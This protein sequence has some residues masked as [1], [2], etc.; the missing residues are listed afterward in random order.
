MHYRAGCEGADKFG[1][2]TRWVLEVLGFL[3]RGCGID[4]AM[5]PF[6]AIELRRRQLIVRTGAGCATLVMF[7]IAAV[8]AFIYFAVSGGLLFPIGCATENRTICQAELSHQGR[9]AGLT[10]LVTIAVNGAFVFWVRRRG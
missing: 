7:N 6:R 9:F 4:G 3:G 2:G 5:T 10:I 1:A 8:C